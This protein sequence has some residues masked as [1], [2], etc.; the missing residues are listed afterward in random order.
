MVNTFKIKDKVMYIQYTITQRKH[1]HSTG[2]NQRIMRQHWSKVSPHLEGQVPLQ[3]L[4][5]R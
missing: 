5:Q 2:R 3:L 1:L 4:G